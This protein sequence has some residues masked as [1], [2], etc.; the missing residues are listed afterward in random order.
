METFQHHRAPFGDRFLGLFAAPARPTAD[1][2]ELH[3]DDVFWVGSEPGSCDPIYRAT[4]PRSVSPPANLSGFGS[5]RVSCLS[6]GILVALAD[7][8]QKPQNFL[9]RKVAFAASPPS[10]RASPVTSALSIPAVSKPKTNYSRSMPAGKIHQK[11]VPVSVPVVPP[12]AKNW[13]EE[14][15]MEE[16]EGDCDDHKMLPPHQIVARAS[17][18][19]S[20]MTTFSV[21]EGVGR[22]LKGR[23]LRRVRN[24]VLQK[25]G[26]GM[27]GIHT[28]AAPSLAF[29]VSS[30]PADL[31]IAVVC[32][33]PPDLLAAT[34]RSTLAQSLGAR[35]HSSLP[36]DL[37]VGVAVVCGSPSLAH[38]RLP[39]DLLAVAFTARR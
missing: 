13:W 23:D 19:G 25:T 35:L 9:C 33:V 3:E 17:G 34:R 1:G 22:T 27:N 38:C 24:A 15:D 14:L 31:L 7:D 39:S 2:D 16:G 21:L 11:S 8:H 32:R 28:P 12:K 5:F 29:T 4:S 18:N 37:L 10:A 20:P 26:S 36:P 6:S 30:L